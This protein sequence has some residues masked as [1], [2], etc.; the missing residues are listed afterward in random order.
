MYVCM[1]LH[2]LVYRVFQSLNVEAV[3]VG[4]S[5]FG[6]T[7]Y[8]VRVHL[9]GLTLYQLREVH[10]KE[11]NNIMLLCIEGSTFFE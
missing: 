9:T 8:F 4:Q 3:H 11:S 5:R 10:K 1:I 2:T 7:N 6:R